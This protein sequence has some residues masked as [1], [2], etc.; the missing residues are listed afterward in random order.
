MLIFIDRVTVF[1]LG[2]VDVFSPTELLLAAETRTFVSVY[3]LL[4]VDN[5]LTV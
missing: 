4:C 2:V 1:H 3:P 5:D